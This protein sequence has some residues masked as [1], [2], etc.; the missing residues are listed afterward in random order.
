MSRIYGSDRIQKL[1]DARTEAAKEIEELKARKNAELQAFEA[2]HTGNSDQSFARVAAE[3]EVR[4][5]EIQEAV[6][7][8]KH[9]VTERLFEAIT[10]VNPKVHPNVRVDEQVQK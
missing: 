3:T 10:T 1:K 7:R 8:H 2:E 4:L 6:Q 5:T 9:L